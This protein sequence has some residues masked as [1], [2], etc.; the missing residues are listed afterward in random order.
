MGFHPT[1]FRVATF[2]NGKVMLQAIVL[3]IE[4]EPII[5]MAVTEDLL[6][7]GASVAEASN[8]HEALAILESG[9]KITA[10][11]SDID[12]PGSIDGLQLPWIVRER[13]PPLHLF[14]TSG[15]KRPKVDELPEKACFI[16]KPNSHKAVIGALRTTLE[17]G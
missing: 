13:W 8:A 7:E 16:P 9:E 6:S 4:N 10:I 1:A 2:Q 17:T 11:F 3:V 12:M 14:L 5:S 15:H